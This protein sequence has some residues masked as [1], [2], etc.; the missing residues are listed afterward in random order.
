MTALVSGRFRHRSY[1]ARL[2]S[3]GGTPL[4]QHRQPCFLLFRD[5]CDDFRGCHGTRIAA[6]VGKRDG[7]RCIAETQIDIDAA[8]ALLVVLLTATA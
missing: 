4:Q 6:H 2:N 7:R 3:F 1:C 5:E 8:E